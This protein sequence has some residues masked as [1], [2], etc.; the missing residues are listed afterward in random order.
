[1]VEK[2]QKQRKYQKYFNRFEIKYQIP[3][4]KRDE[5]LGYMRPFMRLD[6]HVQNGYDYEVR[7][8]YYD[9]PFRHALLEKLDGVAIR[10][11][12]R[13]RYYPKSGK[14]NEINGTDEKLS[15]IEVKKKI[16]DNVAKSRVLVPL[17][18]AINILDDSL[19]ETRDYYRNATAQDKKVLK[20]IWF[21][22]KKYSLKPV[23]VVSYK[24]RPYFAKV[25]RN[26][27]ITF[28]TNVKVRNFNF[29]LNSGTGSKL[30]V[31]R[32]ICIMEVKFTS[33][34]PS[35]AVKIIQKSDSVQY[36]ISK[37]ATGLIQTRTYAVT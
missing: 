32:G 3:L 21:L 11:K 29:D 4:R 17:N 1:M 20:E 26:F 30:V 34:I 35:W 31:N 6:P 19:P 23:C 36:K 28:D 27:R 33:F 5:I 10:R 12:L 22:Y 15:F 16:N 25:E 7:S 2:I 24:R 37:F 18:N 9:S 13:I 14:F 8:L